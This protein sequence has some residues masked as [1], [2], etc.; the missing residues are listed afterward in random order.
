MKRLLLLFFVLGILT[1]TSIQAMDMEDYAT[2]DETS[3][4]GGDDGCSGLHGD[5]DDGND[6]HGDE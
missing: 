4:T 2:G 5:E 1:G 6:L 3:A